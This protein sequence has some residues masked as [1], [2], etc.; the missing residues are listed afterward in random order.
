MTNDATRA[1]DT[2][3]PAIDPPE[4]AS[5]SN[6]LFEARTKLTR[7]EDLN[8]LMFMAGEGLVSQLPNAANAITA[9]A[10]QINELLLEVCNQ[11]DGKE[12]A[13]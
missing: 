10:A 12:E 8:E 4:G 7:I 13:A 3:L 2:A 6:C 9:G 11:L 1:S 5:E